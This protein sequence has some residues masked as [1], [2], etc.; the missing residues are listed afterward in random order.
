[1]RLLPIHIV[2]MK[3]CQDVRFEKMSEAIRLSTARDVTH[4]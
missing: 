4:G 1:M 3:I 2:K